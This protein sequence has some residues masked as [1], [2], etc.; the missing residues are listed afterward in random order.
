MLRQIAQ[1]REGKPR[2]QNRSAMKGIVCF[3]GGHSSALVAVEAVRKYG[4]KNVILL[5]HDISSEVEHPDIKRFKRDVADYLD[6]DITYAN[7]GGFEELT[8]LRVCKKIGAFQSQPGQALCTYNLKTKPFYDWLEANYPV[9][10]ANP[11]ADMREDVR[12]LY[13]F[14]ASEPNRIQR[15]QQILAVQGYYTEFPLACKERTIGNI[16]EIG[17]KRPTTYRIFKHANCLGCLKAGRQH[18]YVIYCL[19]P[20][21]FKEAVEAEQEIGHSIIKGIYLE[22]LIPKFEEIKSKGICP[23]DRENSAEFWKRVNDT[24]PEQQSFLPCDCAVL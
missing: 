8:P 11:L 15:R 9:D 6:V 18:W 22:E 16:E 14:D 13:G 20:Q 5:N 1:A 19:R 21:I 3:Y 17:I 7:M 10:L 2:M 4:K 12:I 23:N 24:L